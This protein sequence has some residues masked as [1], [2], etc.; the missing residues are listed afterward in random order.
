MEPATYSISI[1]KA[2]QKQL[3]KLPDDVAIL[4]LTVIQS[5]AQNPRPVGCKK[6]KGAD[7]YRVRKGNYR[8]IY[9]I[10]DA[11]LQIEVVAIGDRKDV[12]D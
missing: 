2:A 3:D 10:R 6:L 12:Y 7:A 5:L 9:E 8:I 11:V 4:L 1:S